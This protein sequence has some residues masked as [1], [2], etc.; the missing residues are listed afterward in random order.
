MAVLAKDG[1]RHHS[2]SR[3]SLHD[4]LTEKKGPATVTPMKKP[5]GKDPAAA[6]K[7]PAIAQDHPH[8]PG[9]HQI[10]T[11]TPIAEHVEEH[12]PATHTFHMHDH[13]GEGKHHVTSHH[14][15]MG[16]NM[17][18]SEHESHEAAHD[19]MA[20]AMGAESPDHEQGE[21]HDYEAPEASAA[22]ER[23]PGL[24]S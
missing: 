4:K 15:A 1:S 11:Q 21:P 23:I 18:H 2:A 5:E 7:A 20:V 13:G 17:H 16:E 3:A 6:A 9:P 14:G 24:A 22:G 8:M 12:G 19:H 10:P